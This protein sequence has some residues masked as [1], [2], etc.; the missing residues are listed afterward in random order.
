MKQARLAAEKAA[1]EGDRPGVDG[2]GHEA[3]GGPS[4]EQG[5]HKLGQLC[6]MPAIHHVCCCATHYARCRMLLNVLLART[7]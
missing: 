4:D 1:K 3:D 6:L 2:K 5:R 7:G